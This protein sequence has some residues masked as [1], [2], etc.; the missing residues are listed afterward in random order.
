[1]AVVMTAAE[2]NAFLGKVFLEVASEYNVEEVDDEG[3]TLR[4]MV[5]DLSLI[6][7]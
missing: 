7:I 3:V 4:L 6:H 1:M 5:Q 2:M